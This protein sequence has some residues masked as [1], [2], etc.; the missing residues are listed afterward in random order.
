MLYGNME[1]DELTV[2]AGGSGRGNNYNNNNM[3]ESIMVE[4]MQP[5]QEVR[6]QLLINGET[7]MVKVKMPVAFVMGDIGP[8]RLDPRY[9]YKGVPQRLQRRHSW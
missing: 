9:R 1:G 6:V 7:I 5:A 8:D 2:V 3:A 4:G